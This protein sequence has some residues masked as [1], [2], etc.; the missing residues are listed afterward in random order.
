MAT[1]TIL[2]EIS[3]DEICDLFIKDYAEK[4]TLIV[5]PD[6]FVKDV[7]DFLDGQL[8]K[9]SDQEFLSIFKNLLSKG[10]I[11]LEFILVN[12]AQVRVLIRFYAQ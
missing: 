4:T 3:M 5:Q 11:G 8:I 12:G 2:Q 9:V 10:R 6:C 1:K 7:A